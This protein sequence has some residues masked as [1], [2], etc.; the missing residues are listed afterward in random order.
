MRT[1]RIAGA[2]LAL[3]MLA[4]CAGEQPSLFGKP[5]PAAPPIPKIAMAGRWTLATPAGKSCG[6]RFGGASGAQEGTI[7]PEG[8][9]P[10]NFFTSRHW[11]FE[12][13]DL[14]IKDHN[15][16]PLANLALANGGFQG[17]T[18]TGTPVTLSR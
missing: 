9:C 8:G 11:T 13:G 15:S 7:A 2:A 18:V 6:M 16:E 1:Y 12:N 3:L 10:G 5:A 14:V 17:T 4:G